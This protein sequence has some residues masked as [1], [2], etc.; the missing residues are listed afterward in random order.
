MMTELRISHIAR[1]AVITWNEFQRDD[2]QYVGTKRSKW[3]SNQ[4]NRMK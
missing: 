4:E 3:K 1:T 2:G